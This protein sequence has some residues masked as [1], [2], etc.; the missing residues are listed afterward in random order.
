[1]QQI[2]I[3]YWKPIVIVAIVVTIALVIYYA[4]KDKASIKPTP[5]PHLTTWGQNGGLTVSDSEAIRKTTLALF[6]DLNGFSTG[7][8]LNLYESLAEQSDT[9]IVAVYNDFNE[10]YIEEGNGTL[11]E[12]VRDD[13]FYS[14]ELDTV[15]NLLGR[16][17]TLNLI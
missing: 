12:W 15:N 4:G 1:M 8:D 13:Y 17:D 7:H 11:K 6:A 10:L 5:L 16:F 14:W 2:L 9:R 3:K